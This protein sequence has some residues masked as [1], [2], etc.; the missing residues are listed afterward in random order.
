MALGPADIVCSRC[1]SS[2]NERVCVESDVSL[3]SEAMAVVEGVLSVIILTLPQLDRGRETTSN[4]RVRLLRTPKL[5][6]A[7]DNHLVSLDYGNTDASNF[8]RYAGHGEV[9]GHPCEK[10]F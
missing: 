2:S 6:I 5:Q 3:A 9:Y 1:R 10:V 8:K 4:R 7:D